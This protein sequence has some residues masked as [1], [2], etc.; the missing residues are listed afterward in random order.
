MADGAR[1]PLAPSDADARTRLFLVEVSNAPDAL[2]RVLSICAVRQVT[3]TVVVF[4][5][6][7]IRIETTGLGDADAAH[8]SDRLR[9]APCVRGVSVG[10]RF[11]A[12]T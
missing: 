9:I 6:G 10:W 3:L 12:R 8:L 11:R 2:L 1:P 5:A 4:G 7:Q